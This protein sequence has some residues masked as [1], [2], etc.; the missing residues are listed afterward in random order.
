MKKLNRL[1][2]RAAFPKRWLSEYNS[3]KTDTLCFLPDVPLRGQLMERIEAKKGLN[4]GLTV[5]WFKVGKVNCGRK[6]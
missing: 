1:E 4:I 3:K 2:G 6:D 5:C